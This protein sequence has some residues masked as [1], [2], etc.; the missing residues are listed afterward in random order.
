M[1]KEELEGIPE[2]RICQIVEDFILSGASKLTVVKQGDGNWTISA[3][4]PD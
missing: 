3:E 2:K 1:R 4:L